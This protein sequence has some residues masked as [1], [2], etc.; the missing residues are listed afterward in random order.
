[1]RILVA[2]DDSRL[3]MQL[4]SLFQQQGFSIDLA[5]D[6]EKAL[7]QLKEVNYDLAVID[8]GLPKLDGFDVIR[9]ARSSDVST[10]V[11][12]LTARD[13]WQE[14]VEGLDAGADDYLTK[15]FHNEE[16]LARVKAL[17][18]RASGQASS[19]IEFGPVVLDMQAK[20]IRVNAR[21]LDLTAYE[22]K[23]MEYLM[24]HPQKVISKTELT[25]HIYDQDFDLDSNVIEVF[26]G[27]L[28]RKLDPEGTLKPIETLRGRGYRISRELAQD[29]S[30]S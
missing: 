11:L 30:G 12:I 3:L 20:E 4:D 13:R 29:A 5:D 23:V 7:F 25:E 9:Q 14:K 28:R 26:V 18:R 2:E 19:T 16:L 6:G 24:L 10:P 22:Y 21:A 8:I 17:I 1:M 27:R 15:P